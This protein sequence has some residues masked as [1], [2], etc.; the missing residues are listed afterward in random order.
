MGEVCAAGLNEGK[1]VPTAQAKT[2]FLTSDLGSMVAT[3]F[4]WRR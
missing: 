3:G 1:I 4:S 2:T